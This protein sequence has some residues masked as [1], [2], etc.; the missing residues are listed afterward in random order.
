MVNPTQSL[1]M[2]VRV[3]GPSTSKEADPAGRPWGFTCKHCP[4][5]PTRGDEPDYASFQVARNEWRSVALH[6]P[7]RCPTCAYRKKRWTRMRRRVD[8]AFAMAK[9]KGSTYSRPK[10]LTFA[11]PSTTS[12]RYEDR[13]EQI[14]ILDS[15]LPRARAVLREWNVLG[16][17]MV[18]E[19]TSRL[20]PLSWAGGVDPFL[21]RG[22]NLLEWKH[23]AHVHAVVIAPWRSRERFK[24][25]CECLT[26]M[27]L[28]RLNVEA[29]E[30]RRY[31]LDEAKAEVTSY[32]SKY[33]NK[34]GGRCRSFGIMRNAI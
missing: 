33:L 24:Q 2:G 29:L 28:G 11:L 9:S 13:F 25:F 19:C 31:S 1:S 27:G 22:G 32:I 3:L 20:L 23:H 15:R 18:I 7:I 21:E 5:V 17:I 8:K 30:S 14:H 16:G 34:D 6:V 10:L 26:D 4:H 12:M